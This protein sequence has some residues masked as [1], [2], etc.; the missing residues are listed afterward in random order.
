[1]TTVT[2]ATA[3]APSVPPPPRGGDTYGLSLPNT[4][5]APKVARD[6]VTSLLGLKERHAVLLDEARLCTTE[7][8]T[9][10]HR[11]TRTPLI[12]MAVTVD[13]EQVTVSVADDNPWVLPV[14]G[15][16]GGGGGVGEELESGQG[17]FLVATLARAWGATV[18]GG[19]SP[20]HKNVWFT[21]AGSG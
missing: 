18:C 16:P 13:R 9:N 21:L 14:P 17:L 6:F 4:P 8:V 10:A 12:R 1:M 19:C 2:T 15:V 7:V 11:H 3:L 20:G 5:A